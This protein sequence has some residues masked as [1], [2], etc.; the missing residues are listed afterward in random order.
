MIISFW[1][2]NHGQTGTTTTTIL[3]GVATSLTTSKKVLIGHGNLNDSTLERSLIGE[4]GNSREYIDNGLGAL[5]RLAKNRRL[6]PNMIRDY[7][8]PILSKSR[9][10]LLSGNDVHTLKD[11]DYDILR[12]I[13]LYSNE[14][15]DYVFIDLHSGRNNELTKKIFRDS[16][17]IVVCLNQNLWINDDF[18][19]DKDLGKAIE[20]KR[21]VYH[22]NYYNP[23]SKLNVKNFKRLFGAEK[24]IYT[25]S[26]TDIIEALNTSSI[27][28]YLVRNFSN[29]KSAIANRLKSNL[30]SILE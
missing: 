29:E 25:E 22:I 10:D 21:V 2:P 8:V 3:H 18:F 20:E 16:D 23:K 1:S 13:F 4:T 11:E 6:D 14:I 15:Y 9:L 26:S 5:R 19:N 28:D 30:K 12:K 7:T 17:V 24:V 27:V